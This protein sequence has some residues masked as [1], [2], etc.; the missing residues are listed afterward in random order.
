M[1]G[2]DVRFDVRVDLTDRRL[3]LAA[4]RA[5]ALARVLRGTP[6]PPYMRERLD[7]LNIVRA[8]RGTTGIEGIELSEAQVEEILGVGSVT[9]VLPPALQREEREVRN[10]EAAMRFTTD[11]LRRDPTRPL[12]E[13]LICELHALTTAG[14][15]YPTNVSGEYRH[16]PVQVGDY[17]PP[18]SGDDVRRPMSAF[19]AWMQAG[20]PATWDPLVRAVIAHFCVVSI[21]PF[22]DGNGRTARAVESFMLHQAGINA[23]GFYSLANFYYQQRSAYIQALT[24]AR[25][26]T[27]GDLTGF[28][29][30]A[31]E[32]LVGELTAVHAELQQFV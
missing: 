1:P 18:R 15:D 3:V 6:V 16:H 24:D 4:A 13:P 19:V 12:S 32:G 28:A 27:S 2:W 26:Y 10:A 25:F 17:V 7:R 5:H 29:V 22:G 8:L 31:L 9:P 21:H 11:A 14:I 23:Y 20:P 30:F